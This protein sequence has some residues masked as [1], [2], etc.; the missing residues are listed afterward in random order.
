M[1]S[2]AWGNGLR[3]LLHNLNASHLISDMLFANAQNAAN[4]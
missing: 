4:G 1:L 3:M 2:A